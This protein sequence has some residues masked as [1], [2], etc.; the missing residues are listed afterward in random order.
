M[1]WLL[2][3]LCPQSSHIFHYVVFVSSLRIDIFWLSVTFQCRGIIDFAYKC[4]F[5]QTQRI[6]GQSH[7]SHFDDVIMGAIASQITRLTIV[8]S[9][10]YSNAD[11]RKHQ[12]SASLAFVWGIHRGPV[13]SPHKGP[14]TRKMS[15][16]DDVIMNGKVGSQPGVLHDVGYPS[17]THLKLK[18][19]DI[20]FVHNI[21]FSCPIVLKFCTAHGSITAMPW[22]KFQ[23]D[24]MSDQ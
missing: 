7:L 9:T 1:P 3:P 20:S 23:N 24:W 15:P 19:R 17:E 10:F 16:F 8:Y 5:E 2:V 22:A 13:N 21:R 14:V 11:Q 4:C 6:K 18:S 12:S